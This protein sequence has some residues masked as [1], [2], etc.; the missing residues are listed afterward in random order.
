[1]NINVKTT[2]ITIAVFAIGFLTIIGSKFLYEMSPKVVMITILSAL[3]AV[4]VVIVWYLVKVI[5]TD[6]Y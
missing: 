5:I 4:L 2:L 3:F 6:D 1:M